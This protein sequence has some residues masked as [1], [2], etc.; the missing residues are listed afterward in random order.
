MK[1][2]AIVPVHNGG[3]KLRQ[4]L[5]A[6]AASERQ[7]DEVIVVDDGSTDR[8]EEAV[9]ELGFRLLQLAKGPHGSAVARNP[10]AAAA[11]ADVLPFLDA[12][13]AVH[14]AT[15][16]RIEQYLVEDPTIAALFGSYDANP[17]ER[18]LVS[19]YEN[20]RHHYIHQT[21][22]EEAST[23]W[24]GCGAVRREAFDAM[25]GFTEAYEQPSIEDIELGMRLR[26]AG[27]RI[28]LCPDVQVTHL[29][30]WTLSSLVYTDIVLR[31]I[32]WSRLLISEGPLLNDLNLRLQHRVSAVTVIALIAATL[33]SPWL[34]AATALIS[35]TGAL[36]IGLNLRLLRFFVA[37]GGVAFGVGA[38]CLH[39]VYYVYST[40]A[41]VWAAGDVVLARVQGQA[42]EAALGGPGGIPARRSGV[43]DTRTRS[44][45]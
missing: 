7:P 12:D 29:K 35:I 20:L 37:R 26:R 2:V 15:I 32:P 45:S 43:V 6:I 1:I 41:F 9:L 33:A 14:P 21:A 10:G 23:L 36:F 11:S 34:P 18:N 25:G 16:G 4:C 3:G 38:C 13:V 39:A 40:G 22:H 24:T 44:D 28:R 8:A 19:R 31:A 30:H 42:G 17:P 5:E 27:Q